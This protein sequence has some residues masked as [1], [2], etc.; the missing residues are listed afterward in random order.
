MEIPTRCLEGMLLERQNWEILSAE[1]DS[2]EVIP[3][4]LRAAD[5]R[6]LRLR[7]ENVQDLEI[8]QKIILAEEDRV[9]SMDEVLSRILSFY[10]RFVPYK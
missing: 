1:A 8:I 3:T 10:R 9:L 6:D 4:V 7:R 2:P 5:E